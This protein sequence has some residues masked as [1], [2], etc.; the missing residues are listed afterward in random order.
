MPL[1]MLTSKE[2]DLYDQ[3]KNNIEG[4]EV[5]GTETDGNGYCMWINFNKED[6]WNAFGYILS[7]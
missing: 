7:G 5:V 4:I 2:S 6:G 1:H 3:N